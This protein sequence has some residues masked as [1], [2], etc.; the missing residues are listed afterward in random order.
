[1][2]WLLSAGSHLCG[3]GLFEN[4]T[5]IARVAIAEIIKAE[6]LREFRKHE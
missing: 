3:K 6:T 1:V 2:A 5:V 4:L